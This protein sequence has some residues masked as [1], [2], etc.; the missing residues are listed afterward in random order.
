MGGRPAPPNYMD[1]DVKYVSKYL[2]VSNEPLY[3]FGFG[4]SYTTY[5]YSDIKI[6]KKNISKNESVT[7]SASVKNNGTVDGHE[8]VQFYMRDLVGSVARP[9]IELKDFKKLAIKA[10]ETKT[11]QFTLTPE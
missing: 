10:G 6:D 4:L 9:V 8:I 7:V 1:K 2:D 5:H 3:P 11:V